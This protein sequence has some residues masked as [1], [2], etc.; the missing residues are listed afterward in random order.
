[1]V[2]A[3]RNRR[4]VCTIV[5][6][7][8]VAV[9]VVLSISAAGAV[10][11]ATAANAPAAGDQTAL[12]SAATTADVDSDGD[13]LTDSEEVHGWGT[14]PNVADSD[15]DGTPDGDETVD[16]T[17]RT[18]LHT[19]RVTKVGAEDGRATYSIGVSGRLSGLSD[20]ED[21]LGD[22]TA[23]GR[24]GPLSGN[25]T[26]AFSGEVTTFSLDGPA[27]VYLDGEEV[28]PETVEPSGTTPIEIGTRYSDTLS[29][30][31]T[32]TY[33]FSVQE[34]DYIRIPFGGMP[35]SV[36]G[37]LY[38]PSGETLETA[39]NHPDNIPF[40][41]RAPEDGTYRLV[42]TERNSGS[43]RFSV[44]TASPDALEPD[45]DRASATVLA[46]GQSASAIL[47]EDELDWYAIDVEEGDELTVRLTRN[48]NNFGNDVQVALIAPDGVIRQV[49]S[50]SCGSGL[51]GVQPID[52]TAS[53][54]G[55]YHVRVAGGLAE[56]F[57]SYE[58][59]ATTTN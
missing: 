17:S 36:K 10:V 49:V 52:T 54:G 22:D 7:S 2:S 25:D 50:S 11:P 53:E 57:V 59:N 18:D 35:G 29:K 23:S 5:L 37:T 28:N 3:T 33:T 43:Y 26:V 27:V 47:G 8:L 31:E 58:M 44:E 21:S 1:M 46:S 56:G 39:L 30:N 15:G 20:F 42:V 48:S 45:D 24:I 14:D 40:G 38:S 16:G 34:G 9:S 55:T 41:A 12:Q 13:G 19:L 32:V 4:T 6:T 51:C